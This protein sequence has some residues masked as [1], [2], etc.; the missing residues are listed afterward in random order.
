M[1]VSGHYL[2]TDIQGSTR[3]WAA[4]P[5]AMMDVIA[6]HDEIIR[7]SVEGRGGRVIKT[8]G[9]SLFAVLPSAR[10]GVL[11]LRDFQRALRSER[12]PIPEPLR[13]RAALHAGIGLYTGSDYYGIEVNRSAWLCN[14]AHGG[15]SLVSQAVVDRLAGAPPD[16]IV[17]RPLGARRLADPRAPLAIFQM[18]DPCHPDEFPPLRQA[19][20]PAGE[21]R[22]Q[23]DGA[24]LVWPVLERC[25][26]GSYS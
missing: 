6:R 18:V 3:L 9:D 25:E 21:L 19:D 5:N 10:R 11:A 4:Y 24:A 13:V 22:E 1:T 17:L 16:D 15:Q 26:V 12:W 8:Q 20:R 23:G 14:L 2:F 7:S